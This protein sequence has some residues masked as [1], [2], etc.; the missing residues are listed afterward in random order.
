MNII[1]LA[2]LIR[3]RPLTSTQLHHVAEEL[4][5]RAD[6]TLM[7]QAFLS[8]RVDANPASK[9]IGFI[10]YKL[11]QACFHCGETKEA[12]ALARQA[13]QIEPGFPYA[14]HLLG[15][16]YTLLDQHSKAIEAHQR[17]CDLA[18]SFAWGWYE[19]AQNHRHLHHWD[20][21][22]YGLI[23]AI[24]CCTANESELI[25]QIQATH[26]SVDEGERLE[27]AKTIWGD[28]INGIPALN[29]LSESDHALLQLEQFKRQIDRLAEDFEVPA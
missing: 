18:P 6:W 11:A 19:L 4:E 17:C 29:G 5:S 8:F 26:T 13:I 2:E 10:D 3:Q 9:I 7:K 1:A 14:Y 24:H 25:Q 16:C 23:R 28:R 15:K 20:H 27:I 12:E 21:A 22:R